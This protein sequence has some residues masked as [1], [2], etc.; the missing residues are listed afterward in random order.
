MSRRLV[1]LAIFA[2]ALPAGA[3]AEGIAGKWSVGLQGGTD[4]E[5]SG[6]VHTAGSGTVLGLPTSVEARSYGDIYDPSFRGQLWVGYGVSRSVELFARGS[7]Y[8]MTSNNV[9]VGN[10]AGLDLFGEWSEFKEWGVEVGPRLYF[11]PETAFK[12]YIAATAGLR[13]L[14]EN[15]ATFTVPAANVVLN[16]VPFYDKSTVGVF[17]ADLGFT[18]DVS[19]VVALGLEAGIRYQTKPSALRGLAGTGLDNI[20]DTGSR[21]SVPVLGTVSF[22]F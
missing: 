12:P 21:W 11:N 4:I 16:D 8:T 10:V 3:R 2:A 1:V 22:R 19:P 15:P 5:I 17:G 13:F 14:S 6:E 9:K 20:N 7:Y 18:Y